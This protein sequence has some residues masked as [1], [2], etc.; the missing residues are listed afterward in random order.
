MV[1]WKTVMAVRWEA[2]VE[3]ALWRPPV[4]GILSDRN[5]NIEGENNHQAAYFIKRGRDENDLLANVGVRAG[6]SNNG[7]MLTDK[8]IYDI[9]SSKGQFR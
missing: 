8:V 6:N 5:E 7:R 4:E 3:K 1:P 9:I 2:Q